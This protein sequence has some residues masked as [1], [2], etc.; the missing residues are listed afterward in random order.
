MKYPQFVGGSYV[1][2]SPIADQ[3]RT[4]CFYVERLE[5]EGGKARFVLYPSPGVEAFTSEF[6]LAPTRGSFYQN[7]RCFFIIRDRLV[8][9]FADGSLNGL[10]SAGQMVLDGY[11][12]TV[13]ANGDGGGQLFITTGDNGYIFDLGTNALSIERTGATTQGGMLDG[14]FI[15]LDAATSTFFLSDLLDGT[16]WDPTQFA[17]RTIAP[18]AWV[19]MTVMDTARQLWLFGDETSEVWYNAGTFP[20]PFAPHPSGLIPFG[21]AA[22]SSPK[23]VGGALMWLSRTKGGSGQV[24]RADGLNARVVSTYPM[25]VAFEKYLTTY[26]QMALDDAVGDAFEWMG[27]WFYVLTFP[28]ANGTWVYDRSTE[29]WVEWLT[30]NSS[31]SS[32]TGWRPLFHVNAFGQHL[33][34][35]RLSGTVYR[36]DATI[37]TDVAGLP[38]RRVRRAPA[39][40]L[41]G[42]RIFYSSLE[43]CLEPGLGLGSGQ[44]S[45]PQVILYFSDDGGKTWGSAGQRSAGAQGKYQTRVIWNRL[46]SSRDRVFECVFSD[47]ISWK[48]LDAFIT[49]KPG[50]A[51]RAV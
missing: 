37:G 35:D 49:A 15:A 18:D 51:R 41:E 4:V 45:D 22:R 30:W 32:Y 3:Q 14:Y 6:E 36:L 38:I 7:G 17:Q 33:M 50:M 42:A 48:I 40:S 46:G 11:P 5:V 31:T 28:T 24:V 8:E 39:L 26:G 1:S 2:Q 44:G 43:L 47:P 10:G 19:A 21:I 27:H 12:A 20:F 34:G 25:A 23:N 9:I 13:S 29:T 16:T